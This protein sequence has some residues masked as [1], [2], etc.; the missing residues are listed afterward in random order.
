MNG[1]FETIHGHAIAQSPTY[2]SWKAMMSRCNNTH[3]HAYNR[4][5]GRGI[6]VCKRWRDFRNFLADMGLRPSGTSLDRRK[7][8]LGYSKRNCRWA[9]RIEQGSN[10]HNIIKTKIGGKLVVLVSE[11]RRVGLLPRLVKQRYMSGWRGARLLAPPR[12]PPYFAS[13]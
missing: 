7:N 1:R 4:Y 12:R 10:R 13:L 11:A 8:W 3:H 2:R 9:T 6:A 5:G